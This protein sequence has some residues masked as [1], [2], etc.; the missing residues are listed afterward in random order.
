MT[1]ECHESCP[2]CTRLS[3]L[4]KS[5]LQF[6]YSFV[7]SSKRMAQTPLLHPTCS[8]DSADVVCGAVQVVAS[9]IQLQ[10]LALESGR[11]RPL[12]VVAQVRHP[13]TIKLI[14]YITTHRH[15]NGSS[16]K[17]IG[18]VKAV[19]DDHSHH[20]VSHGS[21]QAAAGHGVRSQGGTGGK[22]MG[23]E[24]GQGVVLDVDVL[25]P[26]ELLSGLLTQVSVQPELLSVMND[27]F[28]AEGMC[29]FST[30]DMFCHMNPLLLT[31]ELDSLKAM[32]QGAAV[33]SVYVLQMFVWSEAHVGPC[34]CESAACSVRMLA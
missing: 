13:R 34:I 25:L 22:G 7:T 1:F 17:A 4:T 27:L 12:H 6:C 10:D 28:D 11:P 3:N 29:H 14:N 30:G 21:S 20:H 19:T 16:D 2:C 33:I 9:L 23:K 15:N 32:T 5:Q 31:T 26:D 24:R 18:A 8:L